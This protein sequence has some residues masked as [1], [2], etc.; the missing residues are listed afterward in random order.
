MKI[1]PCKI[2]PCKIDNINQLIKLSGIPLSGVHCKNK[3]L[4]FKY[5]TC[6][7]FT[8]KNSLLNLFR[9]RIRAPSRTRGQCRWSRTCHWPCSRSRCIWRNFGTPHTFYF[10]QRCCTFE[11]LCILRIVSGSTDR[12]GKGRSGV[13]ADAS[14][15][16]L[17]RWWSGS[18]STDCER[19]L[20]K[21]RLG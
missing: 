15:A 14:E 4:T 9:T 11:N 18:T 19:R 1:G 6:L 8:K 17:T 20:K 10:L 16:G 12:I 2:S 21:E 7:F 13:R 3:Y 5:L